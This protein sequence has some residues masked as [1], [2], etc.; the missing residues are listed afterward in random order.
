MSYGT[1][2]IEKRG[3]RSW[4]VTVELNRD[5]LTGRRRRRRF[6]VKGT[7]RDAQRAL[8]DALAERDRRFEGPPATLTVAEWVR[9]WLRRRHLDGHITDVTHARYAVA[10][11]THL[12]PAFRKLKVRDLRPDH[13]ADLKTAWLTGRDSTTD[14]PLSAARVKRQLGV[15]WQTLEEAVQA[16]LLTH[17][18]ASS[19]KAPPLATTEEHRALTE[20]E[21]RHLLAAASGRSLDVP[22]RFSLATGVRQG[23]LLGL[24]RSNV[25]SD[26]QAVHIRRA[27]S[28]SGTAQFTKPKAHRRRSLELSAVTVDLLRAHRVRQNEHRLQLGQ[29][30]ADH[31]LVFPSARGTPRSPRNLLRAFRRLLARSAIAAPE[32]ATWH[33]LRDTAAS[34]WL[35]AGVSTFEVSRRLGHS[36]T[37]LTERVYSHLLPGGQERSTHA[38]DH[39][40]G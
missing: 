9:G 17:N 4:R 27:L 25:D 7:R 30:W 24:P 36:S 35:A 33:T 37:N 21:I 22:I 12:V 19:V 31:G 32:T 29:A 34:H 28:R 1:G 26:R 6:A 2:R 13:I 8:R 20:D 23:E 3:R 40:L 5:A 14:R 39:L 11:E 15:L 10:V 18:P 16:G 38:L